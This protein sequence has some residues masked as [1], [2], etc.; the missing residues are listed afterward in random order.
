MPTVAFKPRDVLDRTFE[1]SIILK[2]L[3]GALEMIGGLLLLLVTPATIDRIVGTLTQHELSQ[4]PH[5]FLATHALNYANGLKGAAL[6]F[7][8]LYL[9]SHGLVKIVLVAALL[10]NQIWAYPWMIAFLGLFILYQV[11]RMTFAPSVGLV[12]LTVF[13]IFVAWLTFLEYQ[14]HRRERQA[15][16]S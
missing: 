13:D 7:G 4:D 8:A 1:V 14:R 9:L 6:L 15:A 2:G 16:P 3:D 10:R 11:Y 5:D 12:A